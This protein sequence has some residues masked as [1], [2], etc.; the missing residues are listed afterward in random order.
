MA[1]PGD[2]LEAGLLVA[3]AFEEHGV[4]Y[5]IGGAL[6]YGLWGVP[7]ATVDV[8]VNVFVRED[9]AAAVFRALRS[10]GIALDEEAAAGAIERDGMFVVRFGLFR[11]D[12]FT[13]SI[14]FSWEAERTRVRRSIEGR[15]VY[16]LSAEALA[17]FKLLFFRAKDIVDLQRLV[18]VQGGRLD[19]GWVRDRIVSMMGEDDERVRRFDELLERHMPEPA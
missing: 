19:T 13:P 4:S 17:V 15:D 18:A 6:A 10:L 3:S 14:A 1:D 7:R 2:P 12:V 16:F 5:A 8:D 11:V 9:G